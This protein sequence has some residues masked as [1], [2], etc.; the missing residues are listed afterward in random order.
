MNDKIYGYRIKPDWNKFDNCCVETQHFSKDWVFLYKEIEFKSDYGFI[1]KKI[2]TKEEQKK[3]IA[4]QKEKKVNQKNSKEK[5]V[6][7]V[8]KDKEHKK[9]FKKETSNAE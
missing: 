9:E 8:E 5:I 4:L 7:V 3:E 1:E 2:F 6:K